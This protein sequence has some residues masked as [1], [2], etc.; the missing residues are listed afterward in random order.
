M[1][2]SGK[3]V[4]VIGAVIDIAFAEENVPNILDA[5]EVEFTVNDETKKLVLEVQQHLGEGVVRAVAMSSTDGL[6]RGMAVNN[7]GAPISVP[8]GEAVL[9]R[10]FDVTG[11]TVDEKG[12]V[13]TE[14]RRPIHRGAPELVDQATEAEILVDAQASLESK[15]AALNSALTEDAFADLYNKPFRLR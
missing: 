8:V 1:S 7:T 12:P 10:I 5:I 11:N 14:E 6:K 4:Q 9:G 13:K 3:I 15:Q 2:T